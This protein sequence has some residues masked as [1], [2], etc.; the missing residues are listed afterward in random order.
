[1]PSVEAAQQF[2]EVAV[3]RLRRRGLE[4]PA[5]SSRY[6]GVRW[7]DFDAD[8]TLVHRVEIACRII[9]TLQVHLL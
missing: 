4:G 9:F 2:L 1:M 7:R 3:A 8:E 6:A 5:Q